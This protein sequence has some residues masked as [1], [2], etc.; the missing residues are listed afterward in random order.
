MATS[1]SDLGEWRRDVDG[2]QSRPRHH[3]LPRAAQAEPERLVQPDLFLRLEQAAVAALGDEELDLL[4]RVDVPMSGV[5]D[6]HQLQQQVAAAVQEV[7]RPGEHALR[8]LHGDD[9]PHRGSR[10]I[11]QGD[12][13]SGTS[14]PTIIASVV[15]TSRTMTAEVDCGGLGLEP[16]QALDEWRDTRRNRGLGVRAEDQAGEGDA[17]LRRGDVAV[18]RVRVFEDGQN[19]GRKGVS[20]LRQPSQ[21]APARAHDGELRRDEQR[22]QQDQQGDDP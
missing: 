4:G 9:G 17:D 10:G 16:S 13:T 8:P 12:A 3:Q 1:L 20:V 5:L 18:E 6:L 22:R 7:D 15:R 2:R 11:L 14:S 21:P 19:P